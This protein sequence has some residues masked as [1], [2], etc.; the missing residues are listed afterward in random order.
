MLAC[1]PLAPAVKPRCCGALTARGEGAPLLAPH[2]P[3]FRE[4]LALRCPFSGNVIVVAKLSPRSSTA[5]GCFHPRQAQWRGGA[6]SHRLSM[7]VCS[8][9]LA[10]PRH[11]PRST[12]PR[13]PLF[14]V[15]VC[16]HRHP[17]CSRA[18]CP[19]VSSPGA[20]NTSSWGLVQE[21]TAPTR[22]PRRTLEQALG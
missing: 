1:V 4:S 15:N 16:N 20:Q 18:P 5:F 11:H 12:L 2:T 9:S 17:H 14:F 19:H 13:Y 7:P 22:S 6:A 10:M 21:T 3:L 8:C